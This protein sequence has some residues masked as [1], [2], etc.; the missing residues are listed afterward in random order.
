MNLSKIKGNIVTALR[1]M[2][3]NR[4]IRLFLHDIKKNGGY[5][6][7]AKVNGRT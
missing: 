5:E 2:K 1:R 4:F 3:C 6:V 7:S